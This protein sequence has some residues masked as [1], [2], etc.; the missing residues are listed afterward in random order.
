MNFPHTS[1]TQSSHFCAALSSALL[2]HGAILKS[3]LVWEDLGAS[4]EQGRQWLIVQTAWWTDTGHL[5]SHPEP[6]NIDAAATFAKC[7]PKGPSPNLC[8]TLT[9]KLRYG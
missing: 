4:P 1:V 2:T 5:D 6:T 8:L 3:R 9:D 7:I